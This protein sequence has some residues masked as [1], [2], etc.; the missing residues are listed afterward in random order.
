[1]AT[2]SVRIPEEQK[3]ELLRYG[4]L[5]DAIREGVKLYLDSRKREEALKKLE[6]LQKRNS[7]KTSSG[8][9]ARL[10]GEDRSR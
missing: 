9:E 3:K 5:S 7:L 10:I 8:E 2:V 1:M 4:S 6:S